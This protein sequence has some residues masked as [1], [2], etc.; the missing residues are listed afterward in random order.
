MGIWV[1][2]FSMMYCFLTTLSLG[3]ARQ[4]FSLTFWNCLPIFKVYLNGSTTWKGRGSWPSC[5]R[6]WRP[7][8]RGTPPQQRDIQTF[9]NQLSAIC[10][11]TPVNKLSANCQPPVSKLSANCQQAVSQRLSSCQA[12]VSKLSGNCYQAV[13]QTSASCL[14]TVST[15][16]FQQAI[17][18]LSAS[19]QLTASN[20]E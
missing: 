20:S 3:L 10:K 13:R 18:Q 14:A 1:F 15:S 8:H 7:G 5:R 2:F 17:S 4:F 19:C 6:A 9:G 16:N 12:N 11:T